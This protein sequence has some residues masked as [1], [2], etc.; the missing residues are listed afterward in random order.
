MR[1]FDT[2]ATRG[3]EDN[4]YDYE[5]FL[6]PFVLERYGEYMHAHRTQAD[7]KP[8]AADNW[9]KGMSKNSYK[10]SLLRHTFD[11]WRVWRGGTVYD[12]ETGEAVSLQSLL[13]AIMFNVMGLLHEELKDGR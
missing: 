12:P 6:D 9:Q 8:R 4:K 5:G 1:K 2:G 10:K 13:C 7:G 3:S 11:T